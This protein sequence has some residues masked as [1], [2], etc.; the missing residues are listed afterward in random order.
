MVHSQTS[1][2]TSHPTALSQ[3]QKLGSAFSVALWALPFFSENKFVQP[4]QP[5][6][7]AAGSWLVDREIPVT[8]RLGN[9]S[10]QNTIH[11]PSRV[12]PVRDG[13]LSPPTTT[14]TTC[15]PGRGWTESQQGSKTTRRALEQR[16]WEWPWE[17]W[18]HFSVHSCVAHMSEGLAALSLNVMVAFR[19][20]TC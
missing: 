15:N 2:Q 6:K 4:T 12:Q 17:P 8:P 14:T 10:L 13:S 1:A 20:H 5:L 7:E 11:L 18:V 9:A 3:V 16:L 19:T